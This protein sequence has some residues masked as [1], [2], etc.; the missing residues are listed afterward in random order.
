VGAG[1]VAAV[2]APFLGD[3][4]VRLSCADHGRVGDTTTIA[5]VPALRGIAQ[6]WCCPTCGRTLM[7]WGPADWL[8]RFETAYPDRP[9]STTTTEATREPDGSVTITT[10]VRVTSGP[11]GWTDRDQEALAALAVGWRP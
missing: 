2:S 10:V 3:D 11:A 1:W 8:A 4:V 5:P 9:T 6:V 7:T